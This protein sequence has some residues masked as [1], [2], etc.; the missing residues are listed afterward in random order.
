MTKPLYTLSFTLLILALAL[1][2][3]MPSL[4]LAGPTD[5]IDGCP[6]GFTNSDQGLGAYACV[7]PMTDGSCPAG[8]EPLNESQCQHLTGAT[9]P[10]KAEPTSCSTWTSYIVNLGVC[11]GRSIST[12]I[13]GAL[14]FISG[15]ILA[16]VGVLFNWLV[17]NT[18]IEFGGLYANNLK[19]AIEVAWSAFR[20][21]ANILIIGMFTFFAISIILGVKE[22][23]QKKYIAQ[24]LIV[25]ILI[26]FSLLFTKMTIDA[27]NFAATAI[28]AA[29]SLG[30]GTATTAGASGTTISNA[31]YDKAGI[32]GQFIQLMG[33]PTFADAQKSLDQIAQSQDSGWIALLHGIFGAVV[34]LSA[35]AVLLYGSFLVVSRAIILIFL[36]VTASIAVASY[37]VPKWRGS[38]Y[39]WSAWIDSL[40]WAT[41][42]APLMM[43]LLWITLTV[44]Y[45]LKCGGKATCDTSA[46]LGAALADPTTGSNIS[47]LFTYAIVLGMLF[48]TFKLSSMWAGKIS[49]ISMVNAVAAS[50]LAIGSRLAAIP[51]RKF[52]G[53]AAYRS[54]GQL[55]E[56]AQADMTLAQKRRE[57][58]SHFGL[59]TKL[60]DLAMREAKRLE[61][62]AAKKGNL[63]E[64]RGKLA[65]RSFNLMDAAPVQQAAK[66]AKIPIDIGKSSK[67]EKSYADQI[68]AGAEKG[69]KSVP[70]ITD[71]Q[72]DDIR[73]EA[74][75]NARDTRREEKEKKE[76]AKQNTEQ[77]KKAIEGLA[78]QQK[79]AYE[80]Q[81]SVAEQQLEQA[82]T[83]QASN[84]SNHQ[85]QLETIANDATKTDP[86]K[87]I[88]IEVQKAKRDSE[89]R[90]E[91]DNI[92][93]AQNKVKELQSKIEN[94]RKEKH[95]DGTGNQRSL[96]EAE[97]ELK[98]A[99]KELNEHTDGNEVHEAAIKREAEKIADTRIKQL[100]DVRQT[101][102][103]EIARK[104]AGPIGQYTATGEDMAKAARSRIKTSAEKSS[105]LKIIEE[106]A[107]KVNEA[108]PSEP[109]PDAKK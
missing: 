64:K 37:L 17:Q 15:Q 50:P 72:K 93:K 10:P 39:G 4:A 84:E 63:A 69:E 19:G 16:I 52:I 51:L 68:K 32:S 24:V 66:A 100:S 13:A 67:G 6:V 25:A 102:A 30:T 12:Y 59:G 94:Y 71:K 27:S 96:E 99:T 31:S 86:Q 3:Y 57:Q 22:F 34:L 43:L 107:K 78:S 20:D 14:M 49:G 65:G 89:M 70:A 58:A 92:S 42:F 80:G 54:K 83:A 106:E 62:S 36:L 26:N 91:A 47:A 23:N 77:L 87:A 97:N 88:A 61:S 18:I 73:K 21:I 109:K 74:L 1:T 81:K 45:A 108:K 41:T 9:Q 40:L 90:S 104:A 8:S 33:V 11:F 35:A 46:T 76:I 101:V 28:Y 98:Q 2:M 60:G 5:T 79:T 95:D 55:T 29:A 82:R 53:G 85:R 44:S 105:V 38:S 75:T 48:V 56:S 103:G 7:A